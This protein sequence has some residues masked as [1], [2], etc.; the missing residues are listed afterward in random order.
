[1]C[2]SISGNKKAA[3]ESD[4]DVRYKTGSLARTD[5]DKRILPF[6]IV[7]NQPISN[8]LYAAVES[9][10]SHLALIVASNKKQFKITDI[11]STIPRT[12]RQSIWNR[13]RIMGTPS[14]VDAIA[15]KGGSFNYFKSYPQT[16]PQL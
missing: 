5:T 7:S 6:L 10:V 16:Y 2:V 11:K 4:F 8:L 1:M 15:G 9:T 14:T 13:C 3:I 12:V